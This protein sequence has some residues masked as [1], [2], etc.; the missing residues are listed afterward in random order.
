MEYI[1]VFI[2]LIIII[3]VII[4]WRIKSNEIYV[5]SNFDN[6]K[7]LVQNFKD[8]DYAADLLSVIRRDLQRLC[9]V[10][11]EKYPSDRRC[12]RLYEKFNPNVIVEADINSKHT[13]YSIN[14]GEKIVLCLRSKDG[15]N[16]MVRKNV[17]MFV[18]LHE[19][20][21]IMTISVGHTKEFWDNFEFL[22]KE[23]TALGIYKHIDFNRDPHSYCGVEITDSPLSK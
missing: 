3:I 6:R 9:T 11:Y 7:Y 13:S 19:L 17:I 2:A 15:K 8:K 10:L 23:G 22:L 16:R 4:Y 5:I 18:A 20:A 1:F 14:K 12:V 21:H